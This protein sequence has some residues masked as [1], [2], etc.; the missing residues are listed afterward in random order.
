MICDV[1]LVTNDF[2][3]KKKKKINI[4]QDHPSE[5]FIIYVGLKISLELFFEKKIYTYE[6]LIDGD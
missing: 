4:Y 1:G 6:Y 3:F 5:L 2:T